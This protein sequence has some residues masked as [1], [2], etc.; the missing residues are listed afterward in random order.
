MRKAWHQQWKLKKKIYVKVNPL[1]RVLIEFDVKYTTQVQ[2]VHLFA[3][4][5]HTLSVVFSNVSVLFT[6][7]SIQCLTLACPLS[8]VKTQESQYH[9]RC[10]RCAPFH[11]YL[12][13]LPIHNDFVLYSL[14]QLRS[15]LLLTFSHPHTHT[16][17]NCHKLSTQCLYLSS[18]F[19]RNKCASQCAYMCL[20]FVARIYLT[21]AS[22]LKFTSDRYH[23]KIAIVHR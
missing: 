3:P 14:F 17:T 20:C 13:F 9:H 11:N 7:F 18:I 6:A 15:P 19:H 5:F 8:R 4:L 16:H 21:R 1:H 10:L 22:I 23:Y 12:D 2:Q